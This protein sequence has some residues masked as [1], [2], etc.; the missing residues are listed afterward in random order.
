MTKN[1]NTTFKH[2]K[3]VQP[4]GEAEFAG[5]NGLEKIVLQAQKKIQING[6]KHLAEKMI[7]FIFFGFFYIQDNLTTVELV[8]E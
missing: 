8:P 2:N 7:N 4:K 1:K 3:N 5:E 6:A